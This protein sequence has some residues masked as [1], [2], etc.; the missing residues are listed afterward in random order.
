MLIEKKYS[1]QDNW[2]KVISSN[3]KKNR[4]GVQNG[5]YR[6]IYQLNFSNFSRFLIF[7]TAA[8]IFLHALS[9]LI[10][11]PVMVWLKM[12]LFEQRIRYLIVVMDN[13]FRTRTLN[14]NDSTIGDKSSTFLKSKE[15][16]KRVLSTIKA[17][18]RRAIYGKMEKKLFY[19]SLH[20]SYFSQRTRTIFL[21][22][23]FLINSNLEHLEN[24]IMNPLF[25]FRKQTNGTRNFVNV[26]TK[27]LQSFFHFLVFSN[28]TIVKN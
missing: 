24:E 11:P 9:E 6:K 22:V 8:N 15:C 26:P 13:N 14:F 10:F 4:L 1:V 19:N 18:D 5:I 17:G 2:Q 12:V 7:V 28:Y 23:S 27:K 21:A 3:R 20:L 16:D 25:C